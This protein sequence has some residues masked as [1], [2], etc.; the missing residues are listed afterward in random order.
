[1]RLFFFFL[2]LPNVSPATGEPD[3]AVPYKALMKFRTGLD[4]AD[5][6]KP[7]VGCNGVPAAPGVVRVGD[8]V[9]VRKMA[10]P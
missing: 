7:C 6:M 9:Y 2:Q 1:M 3:A 8:V 5:M 4:P 10:P